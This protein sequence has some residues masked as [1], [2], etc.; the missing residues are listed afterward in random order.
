VKK[1]GGSLVLYKSLPEELAATLECIRDSFPAN[2][3]VVIDNSPMPDLKKFVESYKIKYVFNDGNNV[4]FGEG[5]NLAS[6][7]IQDCDFYF[8]INPDVIFTPSDVTK[9]V[10]FMSNSVDVGLCVPKVLFPTGEIQ[11]LC[12]R[13]PTFLALL[14]RRFLSK[15]Q[16][17]PL[18]AYL[19]A[20]E[21]R[22]H[23][24]DKVMEVEYASGC[25]MAF[26]FD[27]FRAL[28]GFDK[29]IF[30]HFEDAEISW[31]MQKI[32]KVTFFPDVSIFHHWA[33]GSHKSLRMTW[34]TIK[35][36]AYFFRKHGFRFW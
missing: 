32:K 21:M 18:I 26:A 4:G 19:K 7:Q 3:F 1:I 29:N 36:A 12:K 16:F 27:S 20:Q 15:V 31:R 35:S 10:E 6:K 23:G 9:I 28:N 8:V 2:S 34:V 33:R 30:L 17:E 13:Y 14:G 22:E 11:Y 5:H 24:Y 25:F